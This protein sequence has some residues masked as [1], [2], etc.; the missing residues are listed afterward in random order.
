MKF[1]YVLA[2]YNPPEPSQIPDTG[3]YAALFEQMA[4]AKEIGLETIWFTEHHCLR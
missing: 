1:G 2:F 4:Y 3:F